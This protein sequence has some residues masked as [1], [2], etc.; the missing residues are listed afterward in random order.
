MIE[1]YFILKSNKGQPNFYCFDTLS[2][3]RLGVFNTFEYSEWSD[4]SRTFIEGIYKTDLAHL[5]LEGVKSNIERPYIFRVTVLGGDNPLSEIV[6]LCK[7]NHW[8]AYNVEDRKFL[9]LKHPPRIQVTELDRKNYYDDY[10]EKFEAIQDEK[11]GVEKQADGKRLVSSNR[12]W[13]KFW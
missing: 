7:Q 13:W 11:E 2:E 9:N 4:S 12:K 3:I 6:R 10:W 8:N 1:Q 5:K